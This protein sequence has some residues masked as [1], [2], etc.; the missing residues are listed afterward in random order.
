MSKSCSKLKLNA[1]YSWQTWSHSFFSPTQILMSAAFLSEWK[2]LSCVQLCNS[3]DC[4]VHG[5]LQ[6]RML[7][8]VSY[9]FSR[10]SSQPRYQTQ[11]FHIAGRSFTS[12]ATK[13]AAFLGVVLNT[14]YPQRRVKVICISSTDLGNF[15]DVRG[16]ECFYCVDTGTQVII[17]PRPTKEGSSHSLLMKF[18]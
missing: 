12:W 5:I 7:E 10:G 8:W 11:V 3:M 9:S 14:S 4:T 1:K 15:R 16:P 17:L 2:S 6:A 18:E 13:E